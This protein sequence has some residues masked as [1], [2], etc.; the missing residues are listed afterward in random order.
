MTPLER[1]ALVERT[2]AEAWHD[3]YAAATPAVAA[4]LGISVARIGGAV[5]LGMKSVPYPGFNR[6]VGLGVDRPATEA[7]L[8]AILA[9]ATEHAPPKFCVHRSPRALPSE[10]PSWLEARGLVVRTRWA[11]M[12]RDVEAPPEERTDLDLVEIRPEGSAAFGAAA[13]EG[14][15]LP[16]WSDWIATMVGRTGWRHYLALDGER[17]VA[18]GALFVQG[19]VG[20]LGFASTLP[21]H[22]GRGAQSALLA[23]RIRDAAGLG[24]RHVATET[25]EDLPERPNPSFRN[26]I[27]AGFEVAYLRDNYIRG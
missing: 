11:K 5:A 6:A 25:G 4:R 12:L 20:W 21:S 2:E 17:P 26:M 8:E 22:R 27:R 9:W 18:T 10:I 13:A 16:D 14:F 15:G 3:A 19:D 23:R 1:E 24:C 7:E